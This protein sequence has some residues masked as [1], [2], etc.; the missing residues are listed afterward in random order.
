[1]ECW[2]NLTIKTTEEEAAQMM[3]DMTLYDL[4]NLVFIKI[5]DMAIL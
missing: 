1:M 3:M 5:N 2:V 4:V